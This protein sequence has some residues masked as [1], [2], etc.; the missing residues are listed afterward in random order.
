MARRVRSTH[1][2]TNACIEAAVAQ[3]WE[4]EMTKGDHILFRPKDKT[5]GLIYGSQTPSDPRG[6]RNLRSD[7]RAAGLKL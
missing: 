5:K 6:P 1:P 4:V 3:G 2:I 7:L